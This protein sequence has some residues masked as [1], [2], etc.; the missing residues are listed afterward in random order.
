MS[1]DRRAETRGLWVTLVTVV[2]C[3]LLLLLSSAVAATARGVGEPSFLGTTKPVSP[4]SKLIPPSSRL[5]PAFLELDPMTGPPGAPVTA[6]ATGYGGCP[7]TG[8]D[9]VGAGP[10]EFLWDGV[11]RL[12][13]VEVTG[14][15]ASTTFVVPESASLDQHLVVSRCAEDGSSAA[16]SIFTVEPPVVVTVVVPNVVGLSQDRAEA[17]LGAADLTLGQV[18]GEGET[19]EGQTPDAGTEVDPGTP[20]DLVM[21]AVTPVLV[22][23]PDLI[24]K[25]VGQAKEELASAGLELGSASGEGDAV[26]DQSPLP[27]VEVPRGTTVDISLGIVQPALVRV[28]D[29]EGMDVENVPGLLAEHGLE[30]GQQSGDGDVVSGQRPR[31]GAVVPSGSAVSIS[32]EPGVPP[33]PVVEVPDLTGMTGDQARDAL[34][35]AGLVMGNQPGGDGDV[36]SQEPEPGTLVPV[37]SPVTLTLAA[38]GPDASWLPVAVVAVV[39]VIGGALTTYQSLRPRRQRRWLRRHVRLV[40]RAPSPP[41][42]TVGESQTPPSP[43]VVLRLEPHPDLGTQVLEEVSP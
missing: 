40:P 42:F 28:P 27:G 25:S 14:G 12:D 24:G 13:V 15:S 22:V 32:V 38:T 6:T 26:D 31:P 41:T 2:S 8:N 11:D 16:R 4:S 34:G 43:T 1:G 3:A 30:L 9:D 36:A 33:T 5:A 37:G 19:V 21:S 35:A 29:L 39:L 18:T 17:K 7:Q 23:V 20:V 10:V